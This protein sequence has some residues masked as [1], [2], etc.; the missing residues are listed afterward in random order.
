MLP[1]L[2][3]VCAAESAEKP[4]DDGPVD[5]VARSLLNVTDYISNY[6][7]SS[8]PGPGAPVGAQAAFLPTAQKI[9]DP[10]PAGG[11][12]KGMFYL[13]LLKGSLID[14]ELEKN[15]AF[16]LPIE[17]D[18]ISGEVSGSQKVYFD[19]FNSKGTVQPTLKEQLDLFPEFQQAIQEAKAGGRGG[20]AILGQAKI[21]RDLTGQKSFVVVTGGTS[22]DK[23]IVQEG[24]LYFSHLQTAYQQALSQIEGEPGINN[25]VLTPLGLGSQFQPDWVVSPEVPTFYAGNML[26]WYMNEA[27]AGHVRNVY[28]VGSSPE[29]VYSLCKYCQ[30]RT[31]MSMDSMGD[32]VC[33]EARMH[34]GTTSAWLLSAVLVMLWRW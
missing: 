24:A 10:I 23:T 32:R 21:S 18:A 7:Q 22:A 13:H 12:N 30:Y 4:R 20:Q 3:V 25:L 27:E 31:F 26:T 17:F 15:T 8:P 19:N 5:Q 33:A 29:E 16:L 11:A 14:A 6:L 1:L 28:L 34:A 9:C 2:L